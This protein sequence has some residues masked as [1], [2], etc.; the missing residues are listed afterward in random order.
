M[1]TRT[2]QSPEEMRSH[3]DT[4][5][6]EIDAMRAKQRGLDEAIARRKQALS[7]L[8]AR[9]VLAASAPVSRRDE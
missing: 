5:R 3:A 7:R 1:T 6:R 4:L 9:A 8:E 2:A